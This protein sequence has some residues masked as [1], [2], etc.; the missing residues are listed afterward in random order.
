MFKHFLLR[1]SKLAKFNLVSP[2]ISFACPKETNQ[3]KGQPA[4]SFY[5]QSHAHHAG[6][7]FLTRKDLFNSDLLKPAIL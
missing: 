2:F 1:I 4:Q 7:A 5:A 3:R 6:Q